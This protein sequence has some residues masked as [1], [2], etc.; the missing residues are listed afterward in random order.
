M[1]LCAQ[2][3]SALSAAQSVLYP[4]GLDN[5]VVA[6]RAQ[7]AA[8]VEAAHEARD[9]YLKK[10]C[11]PATPTGSCCMFSFIRMCAAN[12]DNMTWLRVVHAVA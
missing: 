10:V 2:V 1:A 6:S 4:K 7:H 12:G 5:V 11:C 9:A 8:T 3:D